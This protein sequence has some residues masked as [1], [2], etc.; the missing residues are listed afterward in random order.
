MFFDLRLPGT[1]NFV[2]TL[3]LYAEGVKEFFDEL[4]YYIAK[5]EL[6]T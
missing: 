5:F 3:A 6:Y 2:E 1:T 4:L